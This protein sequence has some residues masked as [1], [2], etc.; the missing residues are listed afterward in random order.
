MLS[1]IN[2]GPRSGND[3]LVL[4]GEFTIGTAFPD[5][6][7]RTKGTLIL[8][9]NQAGGTEFGVALPPGDYHGRGTAG[10][11]LNL[12]GTRWT[13]L[14]T[15]GAPFNGI[16]KLVITDRSRK[17]PGRIHVSLTGR[18]GVYPVIPADLPINA[19]LQLG[20]QA[21]AQAGECGETVFGSGDCKF[22]PAGTRLTCKR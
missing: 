21:S 5:L 1:K 16:V 3:G 19:T 6:N 20:D 13:Y 18:N 7:P 15:T 2:N 8:V 9:E 14:N 22:N 12:A 10:W 11:N 4:R 17:A